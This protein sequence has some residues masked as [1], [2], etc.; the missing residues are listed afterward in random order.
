MKL[1]EGVQATIACFISNATVLMT[2]E[3][4]KLNTSE[5]LAINKAGLMEVA[6]NCWQYYIKYTFTPDRSMNMVP[7]SQ[8]MCAMRGRRDLYISLDIV[9]KG[10]CLRFMNTAIVVKGKRL[11]FMNTAINST[12]EERPVQQSRHCC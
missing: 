10:K 9:V 11:H 4:R 12:H 8:F 5:T 1:I 2:L 7:T 6:P 3:N